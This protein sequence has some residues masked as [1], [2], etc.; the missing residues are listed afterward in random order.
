[1]STITLTV[2][3]PVELNERLDSLARRTRRTKSVLA[4][5][6]IADYLAR[7]WADSEGVERGLEDMRAGR[8]LTHEEA[9]RRLLGTIGSVRKARGRE[10]T[11]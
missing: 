2:R 6:A 1:M 7:A 4:S 8:L 5:E 11:S 3:V 10:P 9:L